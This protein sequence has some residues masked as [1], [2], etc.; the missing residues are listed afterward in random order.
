MIPH[1]SLR[2]SRSTITEYQCLTLYQWQRLDKTLS[3]R[4]G[5]TATKLWT[6]N[7]AG[8]YVQESVSRWTRA[9]PK[10]HR[11]IANNLQGSH[12][13]RADSNTDEDRCNRGKIIKK[14][15]SYGHH[16]QELSIKGHV[17]RKHNSS[18]SFSGHF[19]LGGLPEFQ[20]SVIVVIVTIRRKGSYK[21][22]SCQ[23]FVE[24]RLDS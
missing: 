3:I 9:N 12:R 1:A 24:G 19:N 6:A 8:K 10:P 18:A 13:I 4:S 17:H 14:Q 15:R 11:H 7:D 16:R 2:T 5:S 21:E 23:M 20:W 22:T